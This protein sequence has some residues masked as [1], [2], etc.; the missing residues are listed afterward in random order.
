[1][2]VCLLTIV[3]VCVWVC[4]SDQRCAFV[5]CMFARFV[6]VCVCVCVTLMLA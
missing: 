2:L 4:V 1:M 5:P 3:C 6:S